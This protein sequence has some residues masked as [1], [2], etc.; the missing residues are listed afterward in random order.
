MHISAA[1][2]TVD[3]VL[4]T[5]SRLSGIPSAQLKHGMRVV[6]GGYPA[7]LIDATAD[8]CINLEAVDAEAYKAIKGLLMK[9]GIMATRL[10]GN[11]LSIGVTEHTARV[12]SQFN[13]ETELVVRFTRAFTTLERL[14]VNMAAMLKMIDNDPETQ[15]PPEFQRFGIDTLADLK[16]YL[17]SRAEQ[18]VKLHQLMELMHLKLKQ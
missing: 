14:N 15:L 7:D 10:N 9:E 4:D 16:E 8:C 1:M 17:N 6:L 12:A 2:Y 13:E 11:T 18:N 3:K 5:L